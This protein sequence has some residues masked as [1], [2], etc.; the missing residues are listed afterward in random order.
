LFMFMGGLGRERTFIVVPKNI[1]QKIP[2]DLLGLTPVRYKSNG[3]KK[4]LDP[5]C[6]QIRGVIQ[7]LGCR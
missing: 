3:R 2:T 4:D 5:A 1:P 6:A 7:K